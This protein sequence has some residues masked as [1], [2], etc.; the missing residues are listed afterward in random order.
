MAISAAA[1][2]RKVQK[3]F[4]MRGL[5]LRVDSL[6]EILSFLSHF[7]DAEEE[8]LDLLAD[9]ID[10]ESLKSSILDKDSVHKVVSRLIESDQAVDPDCGIAGPSAKTS[11]LRII[12]A[13]LVPKFRHDPIRKK[14][15]EYDCFQLNYL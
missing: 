4:K 5:T 15:Y 11:A 8:A 14:F 3:K 2:R 9:E 13:F 6:D 12:D 10:N 7:A 1:I